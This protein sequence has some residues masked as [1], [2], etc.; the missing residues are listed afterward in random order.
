MKTA[1]TFAALAATASALP[2]VR[3]Q[4]G[5][6]NGHGHGSAPVSDPAVWESLRGKI[7]H[8]VYL[9]EENH[10]FD[11]IAGY[12]DFNPDIDN[13]RNIEFCNDYTNPNWTVYGE[14]L[15]ICAAPFEEEV[16]LTDP[17]HNF[18][19]TSYEIYQKWQPSHND[20]PTMGGFIERQS[21]R[22]N[23]TPGDSAFVIKAYD[24]KKSNTLAKLAESFGFFD[25]YHAE[26]PGPTNPN[27]QFATS[28]STCGMVDNTDQAS[29]WFANVTGTDCAVSIFE[30][31]DKKNISWKN[32]YETDIID[33]FQYKYVQENAMEKLVTADNF[34]SDLANGTL[35]TF[36]Y[37]NPE[38]CS[39]DSMHPTSN[40][41]A[42]EM[43][44]KHLYDSIRQSE[45]WD[46]TLLIINFDEH[47]GFADHVAPPVGVPAPEDGM[48]FAGTSDKHNV[49]YDFT[50]LGVRVP[51]IIINKYITPN[52]LIHDQGTMY[53]DNSA[54]THTSFLHFFQELWELE[55]LNNRV[56]WAKTFE[57]AFTNEAQDAP[58]EL[59]APVWYGGSNQEEPEPFYLLNQPY[60]YYEELDA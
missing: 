2:Y 56:Q 42:G 25:S 32:Y 11:N 60:S 22:Y 23:A 19:G 59:P 12:W 20:T 47:G 28:G 16:P 3:R 14:P 48:T 52:T 53:A 46:S 5:Y 58:Y 1:A 49:T 26:H 9:M 51:A 54:Y 31:L 55:P 37:I 41:A 6:G 57:H 33:A 7:K 21:D 24:P 39:I 10:S 18:A 30:A 36:S 40:M 38:C 44:I 17:D 4:A 13:L 34:Y 45:Y 50:R 29:G 43:M 35:P 15:K 27:R 8:V